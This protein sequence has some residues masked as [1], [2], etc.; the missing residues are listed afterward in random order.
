MIDCKT[1][2]F[3]LNEEHSFM[4]LHSFNFGGMCHTAN[5]AGAFTSEYCTITLVL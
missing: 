4:L 5:Q 1:Q 3:L 2:E